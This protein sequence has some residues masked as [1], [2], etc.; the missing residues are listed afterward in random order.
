[1]QED[2]RAALPAEE[3]LI[4]QGVD[5]IMMPPV[6]GPLLRYAPPV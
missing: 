4:R 5:P 1:M 2:I 6:D 3:R